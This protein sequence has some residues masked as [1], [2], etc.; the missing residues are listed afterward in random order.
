MNMVSRLWPTALA[1][2]AVVAAACGGTLSASHAHPPA[3]RAPQSA[4]TASR[5]GAVTVTHHAVTGSGAWPRLLSQGITAAPMTFTGVLIAP[6]VVPRGNSAT[7]SITADTY[8]VAFYECPKPEP[9]NSAKVGVGP[10]GSL[11]NMAEAFGATHYGSVTAVEQATSYQTP[12]GQPLPAPLLG[13]ITAKQWI[14]PG[15]SAPLEVAWRDAGWHV[16]VAGPSAFANANR[17]TAL[18]A[19]YHWP[20][21]TGLLTVDASGGT[22]H[23]SLQWTVGDTVYFTSSSHDPAHALAMA[24]AM[25][26]YP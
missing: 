3:P 23:T 16:V 11:A 2:V 1:I 21:A 8:A 20:S 9:V 15:A 6:T 17:L 25:K 10:C 12:P 5:A 22:R 14:A 4:S 18:L 26:R 19:H 13:G 24:A 7:V